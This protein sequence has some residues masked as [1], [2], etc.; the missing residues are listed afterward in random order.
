MNFKIDRDEQIVDALRNDHSFSFKETTKVLRYGRCP[1]CNRKSVWVSKEKPGRVFCDHQESCGYTETTR[2]LYPDLYENYVERFPATIDDPNATAR[3]YLE[4]ARGFN[5]GL[6]AGWYQQGCFQH[7]GLMAPTVRIP[8]WDEHFEERLIDKNHIQQAGRKNNYTKNAPK[9]DRQWQPPLFKLEDKDTC[10][11]TEGIFDAWVFY[12]LN[13]DIKT[14]YKAVAAFGSGN[15]P[16]NLIT[17][18]KGRDIVW[19]LAYDNDDAGLKHLADHIKFIED[20]DETVQVMLR[21]GKKDW[22]DEYQEGNL[23]QKYLD[24]SL[25]RGCLAQAKDHKEKAFWRWMKTPCSRLIIDHGHAL[26][27]FK[28]SEKA[29]EDFDENFG[30]IKRSSFWTD[31]NAAVESARILFNG[32]TGMPEQISPVHPQFLYLERD[33]LT[34]D[35]WYVFRVTFL[36]R[37]K[38]MLVALT[39]SDLKSPSALSEALEGYTPG[40][41]FDGDSTDLLILKRRWFDYGISTVRTLSFIGYDEE[42]GVYT[43]V[44]EENPNNRGMP[45]DFGFYKN[46]LIRSNQMGFLKAGEHAIKSNA[47]DIKLTRASGKWSPDWLPAFHQVF[48][49]KGIVSMAWW[50]GTL[51][52]QQIRKE[53]KSFPFLEVIGAPGAGKSSLLR[54]LWRLVGRENYEGDQPQRGSSV[55]SARGMAQSSN[56]AF[57]LLEGDADSKFNPEDLKPLSDHGAVLRRTGVKNVGTDTHVLT[58]KGALCISQNDVVQ[59]SRA[60]LSRIVHVYFTDDHHIPGQTDILFRKV[61]GIPA[62]D[63][64]AW[65]DIA[66]TNEAMVMARFRKEF[67]RLEIEFKKRDSKMMIRIAE[68]HAMIAALI[69]CLQIIFGTNYLTNVMVKRLEEYLWDMAQDRQKKCRKDD[70]LVEQ[71]WEY[72]EHL[73]RSSTGYQSERLNHS[74]KPEFIA[75]KMTEFE[76][77]CKQAG[78]DGLKTKMREIKPLLK[79]CHSHPFVKVGNVKSKLLGH[80]ETAYCWIFEK[81]PKDKKKQA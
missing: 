15:L 76:A 11:I 63:L 67:T 23:D 55:G 70:P 40:G 56:L 20:L 81:E 29:V 19:V 71:F 41:R 58:F 64:C 52:A 42:T 22:N 14:S 5:P 54:F 3:A 8:L 33:S 68:F 34:K 37:S 65:R 74:I 60:I 72:Y 18:N 31:P 30:E 27:R 13:Y 1:D 49:D 47:N 35:Q 16:R 39:K 7:H 53:F 79:G 78:L 32:Y 73:N 10:V 75:I 77:M 25:W 17:E 12:H 4:E 51:F 50:L 6:I 28:L 45:T 36:N 43:F 80:G 61:A 2:E 21:R 66:L 26:W 38:P 9:E 48:T 59:A 62:E 57:V 24:D 69:H 46:K 44:G